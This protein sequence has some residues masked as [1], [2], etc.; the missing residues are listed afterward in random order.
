MPKD[1]DVLAKLFVEAPV[2]V[3][4]NKA[5]PGV[6]QFE[7]IHVVIEFKKNC[8]KNLTFIGLT[9]PYNSL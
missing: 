8:E 2:K 4:P 3:G 5:L 7:K 9:N 6:V 1:K